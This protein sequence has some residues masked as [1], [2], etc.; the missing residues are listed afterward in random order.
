MFA[1]DRLD[2][3]EHSSGLNLNAEPLE[4]QRLLGDNCV[5]VNDFADD[6]LLENPRRPK[7][8]GEPSNGKHR[9]PG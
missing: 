7:N 3:F 1:N 6:V 4:D 8:W 2:R 5:E 9:L